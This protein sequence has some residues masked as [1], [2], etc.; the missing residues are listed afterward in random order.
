MCPESNHFSSCPVAPLFQ[1]TIM[2][3]PSYCIWCLKISLLLPRPTTFIVHE[4][5]RVVPFKY[6]S[7]HVIGLLRTFPISLLKA[8]FAL[9]LPPLFSLV[10]DVLVLIPLVRHS[11][12]L[13]LLRHD[14]CP[15]TCRAFAVLF[16]PSR[17][18][19]PHIAAWP[20]PLP[21]SRC[22]TNAP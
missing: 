6:K 1:P 4:V 8:Q 19:F 16:P 20:T 21:N 3:Y 14:N 5:A 18:S 15:L 22:Y 17:M 7:G 2:S 9:D 10:S 12:L 13:L 11:G